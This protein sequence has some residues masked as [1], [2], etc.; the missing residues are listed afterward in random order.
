VFAR[1]L[2][3]DRGVVERWADFDAAIGIVK[4][5]PDVGRAFDFGLAG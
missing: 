2:K 1:G 4:Q 5:R 3:L